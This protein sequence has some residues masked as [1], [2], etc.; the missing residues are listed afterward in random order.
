MN[1]LIILI[2]NIRLIFIILYI[3]L[4]LKVLIRDCNLAFDPIKYKVN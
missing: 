3:K 4:Y 1:R 2:M